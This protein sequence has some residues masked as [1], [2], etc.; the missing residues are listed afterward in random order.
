MNANGHVAVVQPV[1]RVATTDR[2]TPIP[3]EPRALR[4]LREA[5]ALDERLKRERAAAK[6]GGPAPRRW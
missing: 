1:E 4:R 5:A 3:G 6:A 2:V